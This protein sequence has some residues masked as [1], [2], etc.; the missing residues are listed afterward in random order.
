MSINRYQPFVILIHLAAEDS[1]QLQDLKSRREQLK[2]EYS[3]L[4]YQ[5][6]ASFVQSLVPETYNG[7]FVTESAAHLQNIG[8]LPTLDK[9][10]DTSV[11]DVLARLGWY[12]E[13][14]RLVRRIAAMQTWATLIPCASA[15]QANLNCRRRGNRPQRR[16]CGIP[17]R[18]GGAARSE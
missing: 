9:D 13:F 11:W 15:W 10:M 2:K 12:R 3:T 7:P 17:Y 8:E 14:V 18:D 16:V 5:V 1:S 6:T 4:L